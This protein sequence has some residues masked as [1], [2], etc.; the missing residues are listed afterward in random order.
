L[1]NF[2][3]RN[4]DEHVQKETVMVDDVRVPTDF[5]VVFNSEWNHHMIIPSDYILTVAP[6]YKKSDIIEGVNDI[7]GVCII[8]LKTSQQIPTSTPFEEIVAALGARTIGKER[9]ADGGF[10]LD[11]RAE[12]PTPGLAL[13][14]VQDIHNLPK[15]KP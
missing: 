1:T 12:R 14:T 2:T 7:K 10:I 11:P 5:I 15:L 13:A 4:Y 9:R 3:Q 8:G 6:M